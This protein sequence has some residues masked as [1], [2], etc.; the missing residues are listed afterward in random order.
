[1]E[2]YKFE[3]L[4]KNGPVELLVEGLTDDGRKCETSHP[5]RIAT[6][7]ALLGFGVPLSESRP[8][9]RMLHRER[10]SALI[11]YNFPVPAGHDAEWFANMVRVSLRKES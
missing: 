9:L 10:K 3:L 2:R 8:V 6:L 4:S 5:G 7:R 1:M 11:G